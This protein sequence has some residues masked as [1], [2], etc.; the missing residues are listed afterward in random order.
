MS[1][2]VKH[3]DEKARLSACTV[4]VPFD[5]SGIHIFKVDPL[6]PAADVLQVQDV[7]IHIFQAVNNLHLKFAIH[8]ALL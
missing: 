4:Q 2:A 1:I 6:L 8:I 7:E 5:R 3:N